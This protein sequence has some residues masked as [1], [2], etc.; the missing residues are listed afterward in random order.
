[1]SKNNRAFCKFFLFN[2]LN[3]YFVVVLMRGGPYPSLVFISYFKL[4][5]HQRQRKEPSGV[6]LR[7]RS[8][9]HYAAVRRLAYSPPRLKRA[10]VFSLLDRAQPGKVNREAARK[11]PGGFLFLAQPKNGAPPQTNKVFAVGRG[12]RNGTVR[13]LPV[14]RGEY[15]AVSFDDN[16]GCSLPMPSAPTPGTLSG[17]TPP[18]LPR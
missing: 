11:S 7:T 4:P 9:P 10:I 8:H 1:M 3:G 12:K 13:S 16:G 15:S 2:A 18:P 5:P 17:Y 14:G 6:S